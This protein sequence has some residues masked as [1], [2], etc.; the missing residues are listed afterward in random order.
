MRPLPR[1]RLAGAFEDRADAFGIREDVELLDPDPH[2]LDLRVG[3]AGGADALGEALA[4]FEMARARDLADRRH[5]LFVID[6]APPLLAGKGGRRDKIDGDPHALLLLALAPADADR[7]EQHEA[8]DRHR[9][10]RLRDG[11]GEGGCDG[12]RGRAAF[13][14]RLTM[15]ERAADG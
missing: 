9:V 5:D 8:A 15:T 10:A 11:R 14:H 3:E 6:D 2:P 4:Q 13:D 7:G 1:S 12:T